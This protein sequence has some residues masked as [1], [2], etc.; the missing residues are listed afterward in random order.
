ME[1]AARVEVVVHDGRISGVETRFHRP[2]P[3]HPDTRLSMTVPPRRIDTAL[4]VL[5]VLLGIIFIAHGYQKLFVFG[6][7]G[8]TGGFAQMGVPMPQVMGPFIALLEFFGGMALVVGLLTRLA[9]FGLLCD[10]IGAILLVHLKNG[11]FLPQGFEFAF[12]LGGIAAG[13][14]LAGAGAYS[15][16]AAIARRR[17]RVP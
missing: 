14:M 12:T 13:L 17:A 5:R 16:D 6:L 1:P 2:T 15:V 3:I 11:F 7:A 8:V 9:A 10:M 4:L